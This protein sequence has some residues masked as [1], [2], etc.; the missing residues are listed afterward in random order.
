[1]GDVLHSMGLLS[2]QE[3]LRAGLVAP[4]LGT[5][6]LASRVFV[7]VEVGQAGKLATGSSQI[8]VKCDEASIESAD[9][10]MHGWFCGVGPCPMF[11]VVVVGS[12]ASRRAPVR[13]ISQAT[14]DS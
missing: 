11:V 12:V 7:G 8:K 14:W 10:E 4:A 3:L 5:V 6:Q 9:A 1:M 2:L 13:W